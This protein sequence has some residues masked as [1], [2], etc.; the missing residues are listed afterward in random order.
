MEEFIGAGGWAYFEVPGETALGAYARAFDFVEVNSTYYDTPPIAQVKR[1]RT[2]VPPT[3]QFSLRV[4]KS[5]GDG[6][7]APTS[8]NR[9]TLEASLAMAR[10]LQAQFLHILWP[11]RLL[12]DI[13]TMANLRGLVEEVDAGNHTLC[14]EV[15]ADGGR[16][17]G[18]LVTLM[19][20]LGM[21][22]VT[23]LS[24]EIPSADSSY[25]YTRLFGKGDGNQYQFT[26]A[27]LE[28]IARCGE[29]TG[30]RRALFTFHGV[31]MY[32]DA[33]RFK[34][35][36]K[37]G[38]FPRVTTQSGIEGLREAL[39]GEIKFPISREGLLATQGWKVIEADGRGQ[40][41]AT[42][43]LRH[44]PRGSY[45]DLEDILKAVGTSRR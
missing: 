33:A 16:L 14:L 35:F 30:A 26:N 29:A 31:R 15:R 10:A 44:L 32:M 4:H 41:R 1:W 8:R 18:P 9:R 3:F 45:R 2:Q 13:K 43:L 36:R 12:V 25:L 24:R 7:F 6:G 23:D 27:E 38:K 37:T 21:V 42:E 28:E 34:T 22:H 17:P 11:A 20:D 39:E 5:V 40:A 19:E